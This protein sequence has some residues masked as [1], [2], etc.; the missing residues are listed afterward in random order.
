M[1]LIPASPGGGL[2]SQADALPDTGGGLG[3]VADGL[4][5]DTAPLPV[6]PVVG[7]SGNLWT[8]IGHRAA[9][10]G[11]DALAGFLSLPQQVAGALPDWVARQVGVP[12]LGAARAISG[13]RDPSNPAAP[14][15]PDPAQAKAMAY[16]TTGA[17]EYVPE[18]E[19]GRWGQAAL[20]GLAAGGLANV[21]S[22]IRGGIGA[23]AG[24]LPAL[25]TALGRTAAQ[26]PGA[27]GGAA[28]SQAIG[29][30]AQDLGLP[31][32]MQDVARLVGFMP[33]SGL[34]NL[35]TSAGTKLAGA[36]VGAGTDSPLVASYK[37][38]G[39]D[40]A[41]ATESPGMKIIQG[42]AARAPGSATAM[43]AAGA[44]AVG[45]WQDALDRTS[46]FLGTSSNPQELGDA[47]QTGAQK[48]L[49]DFKANNDTNW[50]AFRQL[51][52]PDTHISIANFDG[53]LS[54]ILG[55]YHGASN[56]QRVF[57]DGLAGKSFDALQ[58]DASATGT[59]PWGTVQ[60]MRSAI[61][62][63]LASPQI[64]SDTSQATLKRLYGAL[65]DDMR[66]GAQTQ[67]G[68]AAQL[69][70]LANA[71]TSAGHGLIEGS[72]SGL[73]KPGVTPE[74]AGQFAMAQ[75][76]TGATRV[77]DI[78][79]NIPGAGGEMGSYALRTAAT[80]ID[81]PTSFATGLAGRKPLF[82]PQ[83]QSLLFNDPATA[84]QVQDLIGTGQS[85]QDAQKYV[86]QPMSGHTANMGMGRVLS[87]IELGKLGRDIGGFPGAVLGAGVGLASP[88]LVGKTAGAIAMPGP[89][90]QSVIRAPGFNAPS[91]SWTARGAVLGQPQ[92]QNVYDQK[93]GQWIGLT[94]DPS[95]LPM[96]QT[97]D[98]PTSLLR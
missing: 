81:S 46:N 25:T 39:M 3:A 76:R 13:I 12:D 37:R 16:K 87:A 77:G 17:S 75:A 45:Q 26:A 93:S 95:L 14:L 22:L 31:P 85:L 65:S 36:A 35:V 7:P 24:D 58:Q 92:P 50:T 33:G 4:A 52:P 91:P 74:Q 69:F 83:V 53:A 27:A 44:K 63:K 6:H 82:A 40:P 54:N 73:L 38:L 67:G 56:L 11:T 79:Q 18:T 51:V 59:L 94:T 42:F 98:R 49:G 97:T 62:D 9:T 29:D 90:A 78:A 89:A 23:L 68:S 19:A 47:L 1:A 55:D 20:T 72:L 88:E 66:T 60:T 43:A 84:Q 32:D 80:N 21:P 2:G 86:N 30:Y 64:I 5:D 8:D 15:L 57:Q 96:G 71:Y 10:A 34:A 70:D 28:S 61:G 41:L 48:W